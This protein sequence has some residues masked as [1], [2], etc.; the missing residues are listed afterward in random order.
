MGGW[1]SRMFRLR[2]RRFHPRG[3]A[4]HYSG[5]N[6]I[7]IPCAGYGPGCGGLWGRGSRQRLRACSRWI[8]HTCAHFM[9]E[10]RHPKCSRRG[11]RPAGHGPGGNLRGGAVGR[12]VAGWRRGAEGRGRT[13]ALDVDESLGECRSLGGL[14]SDAIQQAERPPAAGE[15]QHQPAHRSE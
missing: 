9:S 4:T 7:F 2:G 8:S 14:L 1:I 12:G 5:F 15:Q 13:R 6:P 10:R 3:A 11:S